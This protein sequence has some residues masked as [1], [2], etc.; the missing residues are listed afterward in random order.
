M[1]STG[2]RLYIGND[3]NNQVTFCSV[4]PTDG[5]LSACKATGPIFDGFGNIILNRLNTYAYIPNSNSNSVLM[6]LVDA[7]TGELS[8]C[9]DSG[10]TGFGGPSSVMLR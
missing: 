3:G 8:G 9:V 5:V 7:N 2:T 10:G 4:N 1:N 6:C